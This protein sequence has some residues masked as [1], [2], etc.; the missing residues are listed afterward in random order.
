MN[1]QFQSFVFH[2]GQL[3]GEEEQLMQQAFQGEILPGAPD[4]S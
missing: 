3:L 1:C 4:I 2:E